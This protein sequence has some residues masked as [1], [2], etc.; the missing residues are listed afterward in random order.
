MN[1]NG[2]KKLLVS[3]CLIFSLV[4]VIELKSPTLHLPKEIRV[5]RWA[6][7][8]FMEQGR[9]PV[10]VTFKYEGSEYYIPISNIA[11]IYEEKKGK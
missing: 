10:F 2:L 11:V 6:A 7:Y 5:K 1:L 9:E 4:W 8:P 3:L